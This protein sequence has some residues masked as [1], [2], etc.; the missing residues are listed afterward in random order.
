MSR[1]SVIIPTYNRAARVVR[2]ISS[3]LAQTFTDFEVIVVDDGSSDS[4][5][6]AIARFEG[7]I[8]CLM[9]RENLGVSAARNTGIRHSSAP[10]IAFLDSDDRWLPRKL[11]T[12]MLFF[13]KRKDAVI[14]Q[15]EEIWF[16][17][18]RRVNPAN[19]HL[20]P[21]GDIFERSLKLCLVSPSAVMVRRSLLDEIGLFN[22]NLPVCEDYDLWLRISCRYPVHLIT[23][24]LVI[25]E[26]GHEDQL[27]S[28]YWGMDRF[29]IH[30]IAALMRSGHLDERQLAL[31][32][33]ELG[34]KCRIYA[35]GCLKRG[36]WKE[37]VTYFHLPEIIRDL[38][39]PSGDG[40][41][42]QKMKY[43]DL[44]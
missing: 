4:T 22:E 13:E 10:Y 14:C 6:Q 35:N 12:Q 5:P 1:I 37:A 40:K 38:C 41:G 8:K 36:K 16:R 24:P 42:R 23:E 26:G 27:S 30:S 20:K 19:K 32:Q 34:N 28:R 39:N 31:A 7:S 9:H 21:A 29:R 44:D 3:V 15:T 11:E 17:H 43:L 25:K 2:A 18:G 33:D